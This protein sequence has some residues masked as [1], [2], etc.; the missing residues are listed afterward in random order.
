MYWPVNTKVLV[1]KKETNKKKYVDS[2]SDGSQSSRTREV[3]PCIPS[4]QFHAKSSFS[5]DCDGVCIVIR[6]F[7]LGKTREKDVFFQTQMNNFAAKRPKQVKY[8]QEYTSNGL[9]L[10]LMDWNGRRSPELEIRCKRQQLAIVDLPSSTSKA[11]GSPSGHQSLSEGLSRHCGSVYAAGVPSRSAPNTGGHAGVSKV[12]LANADASA[13]PDLVPTLLFSLGMVM[14][15]QDRSQGSKQT[16][17][18][19]SRI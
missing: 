1:D 14:M 2:H 4:F 19:H 10:I 8:V 17:I 18:E 11:A 9:F 7:S 5:R 13:S 3:G 16:N 12:L 15:R 6:Y